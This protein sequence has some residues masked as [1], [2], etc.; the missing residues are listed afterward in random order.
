MSLNNDWKDCDEEDGEDGE[1]RSRS[2]SGS[3]FEIKSVMKFVQSSPC[4]HTHSS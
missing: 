1:G 4:S 3:H 2:R